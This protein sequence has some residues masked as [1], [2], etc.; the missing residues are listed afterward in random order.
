MIYSGHT[1]SIGQI[2]AL[3]GEEIG[4]KSPLAK[5]MYVNPID[6]FPGLRTN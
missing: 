5:E 1:S 3:T 6:F 2:A 4:N